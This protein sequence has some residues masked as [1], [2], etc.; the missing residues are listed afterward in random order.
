MEIL[1][2]SSPERA[3]AAR[4][5][6]VPD[7]VFIRCPLKDMRL[8]PVTVCESCPH[9]HGLGELTSRAD[10][11]FHRRFNVRCTGGIVE[12]QIV[13]FDLSEIS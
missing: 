1:D 4:E 8:S 9:F 3:E 5:V 7:G 10:I 13:E 2:T 11:A 12:R 6:D